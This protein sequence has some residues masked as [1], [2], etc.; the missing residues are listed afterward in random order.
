[1]N[2]ARTRKKARKR[3]K[4]FLD[5]L[6]EFATA[7]VWKQAQT[8]RN[9]GRRSPR[10][11][12]QS[13]IFVLLAMTWTCGDSAAE[14]FETA[15]AFCVVCQSKRR[16]PGKTVEGFQKALARLPVSTLRAFA[17]AVRQRIATLFADRWKVGEFVPLGCDGSRLECPRVAELESRLGQ[18]GKADSAPTV[19]VTA[20]VHLTLGIPWAWCF[21]KGTASER[22]HLMHLLPTLPRHALVIC[23]AGYIGFALGREILAAGADFLIR[24]SSLASLYSHEMTLLETFQEGIFY[25][26]PDAMQRA[27]RQPLEVRLIRIRDETKKHDVWL[28][29][30]VFE[31]TRLSLAMAS[32]FYRWRWENEG[33][34]RTYKRTLNKVKLF[35]RTVRL[36][37][38][39]AEG[40]LL[41]VQLLLAQGTRAMPKAEKTMEAIKCSP[42]RVLLEIRREMQGRAGC[43]SSRR[44]GE[45]IHHARREDRTRTTAKAIR[46]WPRRGD[47]QPPKSPRFLVLN[48]QQ[49][50]LLEKLLNAV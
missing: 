8:A 23:D 28:L 47:H 31:S 37:H 7:S 9:Q 44:F 25:Y 16:R 17:R 13:L 4:T 35:S 27:K 40:S 1:M 49:K 24:A 41:A 14:R 21:G 32:T 36:V 10:W 48:D 2:S 43:R 30:S 15:R 42:R 34:F 20:L 50:A 3:T 26:W 5:C 45:R 18:A 11:K 6:R 19:W 38:R 33:L 46:S 12:T 39:E 22:H 29:T